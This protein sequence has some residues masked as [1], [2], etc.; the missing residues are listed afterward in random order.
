MNLLKSSNMNSMT[1]RKIA[2]FDGED[3]SLLFLFCMCKHFMHKL[4]LKLVF[5]WSFY[6]NYNDVKALQSNT[7]FFGQLN[8]S[9]MYQFH[10]IMINWDTNHHLFQIFITIYFPNIHHDASLMHSKTITMI[11]E[12]KDLT[13]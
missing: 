12:W 13:S 4:S 6:Y 9:Y 2:S 11:F 8:H 10:N 5:S 7:N 3:D 1:S